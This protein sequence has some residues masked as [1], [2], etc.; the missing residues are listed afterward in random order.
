MGLPPLEPESNA[1]ASSAI[2]AYSVL[3]Q[4]Q[5]QL[6]TDDSSYYSGC[7]G[8]CQGFFIEKFGLPL[9]F[10]SFD[11]TSIPKGFPWKKSV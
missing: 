6:L 2:S 8:K 10:F 5:E 4:R 3:S 11:R 1:S 7:P 9:G